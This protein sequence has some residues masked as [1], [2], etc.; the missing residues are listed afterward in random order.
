LRCSDLKSKTKV[1]LDTN[2]LLIPFQFGVDI[3]KELDIILPAYEILVPSSVLVEL[4]QLKVKEAKPAL[5][6]AQQFK[7]VNVEEKGD[8]AIIKIAH[9]LQAVVVTNDREL[10]KQL[11][12]L[13]IKVIFMRQKSYLSTK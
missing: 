9:E 12:E 11:E 4:N 7:T 13:G 2:A 1:I 8:K 5:K 6:Y 10:R 3:V